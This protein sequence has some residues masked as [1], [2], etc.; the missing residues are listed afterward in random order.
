M[1]IHVLPAGQKAY[2]QS[3]LLLAVD[4]ADRRGPREELKAAE[5]LHEIA[6]ERKA[7]RK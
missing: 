3:R 5:L 1:I 4:L 6:I 7:D 2:P